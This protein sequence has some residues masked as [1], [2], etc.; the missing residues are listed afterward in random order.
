MT[1]SNSIGINAGTSGY[2]IT[3]AAAGSPITSTIKTKVGAVHLLS[4][5]AAAVSGTIDFTS[6][7]TSTYKVYKIVITGVYQSSANRL[8]MQVSTDN[9]STWQTG[10]T[11]YSWASQTITTA[12]ALTL[13]GDN[14]DAGCRISAG[15]SSTTVPS[16]QYEIYI[17]DPATVNCIIL[18]QN[19]TSNTSLESAIHVTAAIDVDAIRFATGGGTITAGTFSLYGIL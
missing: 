18:C 12:G 2:V 14:A 6:L 3:S 10:G 16:G 19:N 1:T 11:D 8:V 17:I 5:Q 7:I 15:T 9:G 4:T 13:T